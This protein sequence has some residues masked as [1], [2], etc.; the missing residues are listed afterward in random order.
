[1]CRDAVLDDPCDAPERCYNPTAPQCYSSRVGLNDA[2]YTLN[3]TGLPAHP[4]GP[5]YANWL[6]GGN[7]T[8]F[9]T[10]LNNVVAGNQLSRSWSASA[11]DWVTVIEAAGSYDTLNPGS[12]SGVTALCNGAT[13]DF[14]VKWYCALPLSAPHT[15]QYPL[16]ALAHATEQSLNLPLCLWWHSRPYRFARRGTVVISD[17]LNIPCGTT[18]SEEQ[19]EGDQHTYL[20]KD[21]A[22]STPPLPSVDLQAKYVNVFAHIYEPVR[23]AKLPGQSHGPYSTHACVARYFVDGTPPQKGGAAGYKLHLSPDNASQLQRAAQPQLG[24]L[25]R[26]TNRQ[27]DMR[28]LRRG[29]R[30]HPV[31]A[32]VC[33]TRRDP[34]RRQGQLAPR[35]LGQHHPAGL[36]ALRADGDLSYYV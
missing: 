18:Q 3:V 9:V 27:H 26:S 5:T 7:T 15:H 30:R 32:E 10:N 19:W 21:L 1:M 8:G 29:A 4:H 6:T 16:A 28:V 12:V 36:L 20:L 13:V 25:T 24:M 14:R 2:R 35:L 17:S 22:G 31:L 34:G 33:G 11:M 23:S